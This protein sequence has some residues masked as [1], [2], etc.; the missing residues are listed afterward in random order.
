M[1]RGS[2]LQPSCPLPWP[3]RGSCSRPV[4][5]VAWP[6]GSRTCGAP[7]LEAPGCVPNEDLYYYYFPRDAIR[8]IVSGGSTRGQF[9]ASQQPSFYRAAHAAPSEALA[10]WQQTVDERSALYMA[11]ARGAP[12]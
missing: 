5:S 7:W 6:A 1:P 8:P 3:V 4:G 9:L 12:A 2:R 10:L 11:E